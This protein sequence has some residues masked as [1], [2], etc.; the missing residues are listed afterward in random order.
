MILYKFIVDLKLSKMKKIRNLFNHILVVTIVVLSINIA[1]SQKLVKN[2]IVSNSGTYTSKA[3]VCQNKIYF[4]LDAKNDNEKGIFILE[5][6]TNGADY[7]IVDFN[8]NIPDNINI[9]I[10]YCFKEET[11]PITSSTYRIMKYT[12][13]KSMVLFTYNLF[14]EIDDKSVSIDTFS[15]YRS[16]AKSFEEKDLKESNIINPNPARNIAYINNFLDYNFNI[17]NMSGKKIKVGKI[18]SNNFSFSL[19][20]FNSGMYV[21]EVI[22]NGQSQFDK[23]IIRK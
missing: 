18:Y 21:I 14:N 15:E 23:F 13:N 19:D 1:S 2:T 12:V 17:Y 10:L 9:P 5:V 8:V 22:K 7:K 4:K 6:S 16:P 3:M 20:D 11:L